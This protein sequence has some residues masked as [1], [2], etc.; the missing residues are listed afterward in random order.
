ML[1][2]NLSR[3]TNHLSQD[4]INQQMIRCTKHYLAIIRFVK[5]VEEVF[6]MG[7]FFQFLASGCG[8]CITGVQMIVMPTGSGR[9]LTT[10]TYFIA[11][12]VQIS[13]YCLSGEQLIAEVR[14]IKHNC[15][16]DILLGKR[17]LKRVSTLK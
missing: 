4:D 8:M 12:V 5:L 11:L 17:K 3:I 16:Q 13:V 1:K 15:C 2:N 6:G 14:K 9:F 10:F 7:L